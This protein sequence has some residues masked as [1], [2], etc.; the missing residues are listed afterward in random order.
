M[1]F[2][3]MADLNK[4]IGGRYLLVNIVA[5]RARNIQEMANEAEQ[6][7][8]KKPVSFAIEEIAS[9]SLQIEMNKE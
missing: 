6:V 4:R 3:S 7:L 2:D 9:G 1:L 8:D 5:R